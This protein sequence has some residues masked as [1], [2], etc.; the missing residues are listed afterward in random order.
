MSTHK[1]LKVYQESLKL[2][3]SIYRITNDFPGTELYGLTSQIRRSAIS[4]PSNISEGAARGSSKEFK[5]FLRISLA[6]LSELETQL[7]ISYRI[8]LTQ[9][10]DELEKQII[11]IRIMLTKLIRKISIKSSN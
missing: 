3:Q 11:Y 6:S 8:Q 9:K 10:S 7:E 5:R 4:I 2:V 1:D